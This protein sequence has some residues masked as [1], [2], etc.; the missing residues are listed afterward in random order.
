MYCTVMYCTVLYCTV[1]YCTILY[2][3]VL[4]QIRK[5]AHRE[6]TNTQRTENSKTEATLIPCGSWV[7]GQLSVIAP[8]YLREL[9]SDWEIIYLMEC[10]YNN[11]DNPL[12]PTY[13]FRHFF[14]SQCVSICQTT[15]THKGQKVVWAIAHWI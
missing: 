2:C 8:N 7:A 9:L 6:Q 13:K 4:E 5:F 14:L 1:L 3:T 10:M 11:F 15:L 12:T